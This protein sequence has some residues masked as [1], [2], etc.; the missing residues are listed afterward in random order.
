MAVGSLALTEPP[1]K[2]VKLT[3]R[4]VIASSAAALMLASRAR[5]QQSIALTISDTSDREVTLLETDLARLPWHE[6]STETRWTTGVQH[7][8]GPSLLAALTLKT[9]TEADLRGR[10]LLLRAL[11]EF[12]VEIPAD[13]MWEFNPLLAREMNGELLTVRN[14][15]PI[16]VVY[17][18]DD[19]PRL[20]NPVYDEGW[21]WQLHEIKIL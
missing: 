20:L 11:N 17:P 2:S 12:E 3:R 18:R 8:R 10:R 1:A 19:D 21:V 7:F 14:R 13:H 4:A 6:V 15:G 5:A 9:W 16:W